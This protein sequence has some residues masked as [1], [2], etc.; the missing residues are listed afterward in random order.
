MRIARVLGLL[1]LL[2]G[3]A[4]YIHRAVRTLRQ[5][6]R[7]RPPVERLDGPGSRPSAGRDGP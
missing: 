1:V 5:S 6:E 4:L 7:A 3:V 2:Q